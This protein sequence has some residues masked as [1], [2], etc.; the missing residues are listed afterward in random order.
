MAR[1]TAGPSGPL[2]TFFVLGALCALTGVAAGAVGAHGLRGRVA[3]ESLTVFETAVRYQM[4]HA[5]ALLAVAWASERWPGRR[6]LAA[7]WLFFTGTLLFSGSLYLIVLT[8]LR[9]LGLLTPLG[10]V[11]FLAGWLCLAVAPQGRPVEPDSTKENR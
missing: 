5:F 8:G 2:R 3:P 6:T 7:G 9:G 10:G 1:T 4:Y 11:A